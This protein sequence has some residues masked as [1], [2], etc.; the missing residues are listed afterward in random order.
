MN[1]KFNFKSLRM[2]V[3]AL[4]LADHFEAEKQTFV[5]ENGSLHISVGF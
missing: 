5:A 4:T 1:Q 2:L 3:A